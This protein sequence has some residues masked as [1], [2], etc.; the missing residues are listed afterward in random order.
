MSILQ[1]KKIIVGVT[2]S[3]AAYKS[4]VLVRLLIK[5]GAEVQVI[6]TNA[7]QSFITS[8]TLATLSKRPAL[9]EFVQN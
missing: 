5:A 9:S 3:I 4:A 8:L 7:A 1:N 2:G 6:M